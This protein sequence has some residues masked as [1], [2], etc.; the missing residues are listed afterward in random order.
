MNLSSSLKHSINN[1]TAN[2]TNNNNTINNNNI[3][4]NANENLS[5]RVISMVQYREQPV[6]IGSPMDE[7]FGDGSRNKPRFKRDWNL[8]KRVVKVM[9]H[10]NIIFEISCFDNNFLFWFSFNLIPH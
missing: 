1:S 10:S 4:S 5:M 6:L 2:I 8:D 7:L 9:N 3:D